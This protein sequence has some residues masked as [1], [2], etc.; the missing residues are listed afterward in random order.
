MKSVGQVEKA[1]GY[2]VENELTI[3]C[4]LSTIFFCEETIELTI[5]YSDLQNKITRDFFLN[6]DKFRL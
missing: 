1:T 2:E 4:P 3:V 5:V 6:L